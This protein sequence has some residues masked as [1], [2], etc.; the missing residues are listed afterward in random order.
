MRCRSPECV[1]VK[2][3]PLGKVTLNCPGNGLWPRVVCIW[4]SFP[5]GS[6]RMRAFAGTQGRW[7]VIL[8]RPSP[9]RKQTSNERPTSPTTANSLR[10]SMRL[11]V[12]RGWY[13]PLQTQSRPS[14][15][16]SRRSHP[17][18][19]R[20][21]LSADSSGNSREIHFPHYA[22]QFPRVLYFFSY[23]HVVVFFNT[24][25]VSMAIIAPGQLHL[26]HGIYPHLSLG[27]VFY[28]RCR[29]YRRGFYRKLPRN[30][31]K[32]LFN[33]K[34]L[35]ERGDTRH[36]QILYLSEQQSRSVRSFLAVRVFR[37]NLIPHSSPGI[38]I[39]YFSSDELY[40]RG[41]SRPSEGRTKFWYLRPVRHVLSTI[42]RRPHRE[43]AKLDSSISRKASF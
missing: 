20:L 30:K 9:K 38:V 6:T 8:R 26:L 28:D 7:P 5:P 22:I 21:L 27:V 11:S 39:P 40:H 35:F 37:T 43:T 36:F 14:L 31:K 4:T 29:L 3:Y 23:N 1:M 16:R 33:R 25:Y 10:F 32:N 17:I 34:H 15:S 42:G 41:L 12:T 2:E 18:V 13:R 24:C 19:K